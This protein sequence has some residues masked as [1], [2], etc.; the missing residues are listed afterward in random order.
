MNLKTLNRCIARALTACKARPGDE[1]TRRALAN[2][3]R[4]RFH[5][6]NGRDFRAEVF[7]RVAAHYVTAARCA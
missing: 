5:L 3:N 1:N 6:V 2:L 4:A 7:A